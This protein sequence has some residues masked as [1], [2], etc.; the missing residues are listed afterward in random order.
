VGTGNDVLIAGFIIT[1][2]AAK[3]V[4]VRGIGPSLS[5]FG[6]SSP[7]ADPVLELHGP[8][9]FVTVMNDNWR[10]SQTQCLETPGLRPTNDLESAICGYSLNPGAYTAILKGKNNGVGVGLVEVY[11]VSPASDSKL[12][13]VS[14]RGLVFLNSAENSLIAGTILLGQGSQQVLVRGIGPSLNLPFRLGNPLIRLVDAN[15]AVL[16]ENNDWRDDQEAAISATGLAPTNDQESAILET[17][18]AN[19]AAYTVI[20]TDG[21][22]VLPPIGPQPPLL[23]G[24]ALVEIYR[25]P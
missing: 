24:A 3:Q 12:A 16:R 9:G 20:L 13:N 5:A 7:L 1:G 25:L 23:A 4:T 21:N 11:D 17:L 8:S 10:D 22:P 18:P 6:V 19:G 14:T 2:N 15:G